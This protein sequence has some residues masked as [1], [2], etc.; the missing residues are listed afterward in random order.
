M[1]D[2]GGLGHLVAV[3]EFSTNTQLRCARRLSFASAPTCICLVVFHAPDFRAL[4]NESVTIVIITL[5]TMETPALCKGL[6]ICLKSP[7]WIEH[8][9]CKH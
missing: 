9:K 4:T 1:K 5:F 2:V 7:V 6:I 3:P 8:L